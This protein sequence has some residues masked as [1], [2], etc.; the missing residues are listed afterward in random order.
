M[1][2]KSKLNNTTDDVCYT[3]E[4]RSRVTNTPIQEDEVFRLL[5]EPLCNVY[6]LKQEQLE[7]KTSR[8]GFVTVGYK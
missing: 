8:K 1:L 4:L 6:G 2:Y 5:C 3:I 7:L